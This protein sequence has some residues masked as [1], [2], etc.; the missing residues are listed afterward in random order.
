MTVPPQ[1]TLS[2]DV[3]EWFQVANHAHA[4]PRESWDGLESRVELAMGRIL[5]LLRR[6]EARATFFFLGW[7]AERHPDLVRRVIDGGHEVASHGYDH[8]FLQELDPAALHEDLERTELALAAAGAP[9][10]RG[11]RASTFTLTRRTWW[12]FDVLVERGYRYDSSVHPI[13]HP[14]Y[15][16]PGFEPGISTIETE[17]GDLVEFPVST[18]P[19]LGR[20]WP[21]GGGGYF[22]LL[23]GVV[24]RALFASLERMGRPTATY[25]HPWEVDPD[26]PRVEA[27]LSKRFRHRVGLG[28]TLAKL[29]AFLERFPC[30]TMEELLASRG[31]L[32]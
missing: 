29:E 27:P 24:P 31:D 19:L 16:V 4:C 17:A 23:P 22:R 28:S 9:R 20:N 11:F 26:Q 10:P 18:Y 7:I 6:R 14:D 13:R 12:A 21:V 25:L 1:H 3:E 8:R 30:V 2:F 32:A 5:D 15:G